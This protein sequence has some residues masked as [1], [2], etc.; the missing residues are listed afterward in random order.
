MSAIGGMTG[1]VATQPIIDRMLRAMANRGPD[2]KGAYCFADSCLLHTN[3]LDWDPEPE[4]IVLD[5]GK[6]RFVIT[7]DGILFNRQQLWQELEKLEHLKTGGSDGEL[8]LRLY[9]AYGE[10]A[11]E[12]CNGSFAFA[13]LREPENEVFLARDPMGLRPLYYT[14]QGDFM[15]F[16]SEIKI[17]LAHPEIQPRLDAQG[18]GELILLGP[19][20]MPDSGVLQGIRQLKPGHF[21]KVRNGKLE[22]GCYWKL[23]DRHHTESFEDTARHVRELIKDSV[24]LQLSCVKS[25]GSLLSG[26]LD[27]SILSALLARHLDRDGHVL[28]TFS[29]DYAENDRYFQP[30]AYQP[31]QD[32]E[33]IRI[34][35]SVLDSHHCWTVL[36]PEEVLS[37]LEQAMLARDLP[38]MADVDASLLCFAKQIRQKTAVAFSGECADELFGGYPWYFE[39][40]TPAG[41]PWAKNTEQ[42]K[43]LLHP[44]L[45]Q[46]EELGD[47]VEACYAQTLADSHILPD[48]TPRE[49]YS[50]QMYQLNIQWFMQTLCR[51]NDAMGHSAGLLLLTPFCDKRIVEYLYSVPWEQKAYKGREKGL[52]RYA[53]E[54]ILPQSILTR[55]KS[56]YPKIRH[57]RY[58]QMVENCLQPLLQD[59]KAMLW[60]IW[61]RS[62]VL[63][64]LASD[65]SSPWYGQLMRKPQFMG[66]LLQMDT[67]LKHYGIEWI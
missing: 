40:N 23:Q 57:P 19:G 37:E 58:A 64:Y 27:S 22:L 30:D 32:T 52:L 34:M 28:Q 43:A 42:R 18:A 2:G 17:L 38:G 31:N 25:A 48:T 12:K 55:K 67:W 65:H 13:I 8:M 62:A 5:R 39:E 1:F 61:D 6:H 3:S 4:P 56:P 47:M 26:G 45:Q 46:K 9:M 16:G 59:E 66:Y 51:R 60:S 53:M 35:Q 50:R 36:T 54:E 20:I 33:Y 7:F 29:V 14:Q 10:A 15:A 44:G 41:F 24:S 11:L 63:D 21:A 49:R